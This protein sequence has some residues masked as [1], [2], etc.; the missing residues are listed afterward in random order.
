MYEKVEIKL[1]WG[2]LGIFQDL[3]LLNK[4]KSEYLGILT[5]KNYPTFSCIYVHTILKNLPNP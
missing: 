1:E 3:P 2:N 4:T 5:A